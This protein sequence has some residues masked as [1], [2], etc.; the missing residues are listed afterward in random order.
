MREQH[1]CKIDE[2]DEMELSNSL[3]FG[4]QQLYDDVGSIEYRAVGL[5]MSA[6][7]HEI[8]TYRVGTEIGG[9]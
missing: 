5:E 7:I 8:S 9:E 6:S 1:T 2:V 3:G 4:C